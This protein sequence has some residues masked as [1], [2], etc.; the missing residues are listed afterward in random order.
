MT[1]ISQTLKTDKRTKSVIKAIPLKTK[2]Y[3]YYNNIQIV[4]STIE[5]KR[6]GR[7]LTKAIAIQQ[8]NRADSRKPQF[9]TFSILQAVDLIQ[10][11]KTLLRAVGKF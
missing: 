2:V 4:L 11:G 3:L 10:I 5:A 1:R 8:S 9:P 7:I 6:I